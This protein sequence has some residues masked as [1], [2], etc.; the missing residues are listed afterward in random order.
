[1]LNEGALYALA[2]IYH[3]FL[4]FLSEKHYI[5]VRRIIM[6]N[7]RNLVGQR[8]GRLTVVERIRDSVK[9]R[10]NYR[11]SCDCGN[12]TLVFH[13]S[14][15]RSLTNS[16]GCVRNECTAERNRGNATHGESKTS[17][18]S[19]WHTMIDRCECPTAHAYELYGGRGIKVCERWRKSFIDFKNDMGPRPN[20]LTIDRI[21]SNGNYTPENCRW[22]TR[23]EQ[24]NN[25]RNNVVLEFQGQKMNIS[26]WADAMSIPRT[27]LYSRWKRGWSTEEILS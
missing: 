25:K 17:L 22:A 19:L 21:D 20:K 23:K 11:C 12:E 7:I 14:L 5:R 26:Q 18:Y 2:I 3:L 16:C 10:T 13:G 1:M 27:R 15:T 24:S 4:V 9:K 8:F 6:S